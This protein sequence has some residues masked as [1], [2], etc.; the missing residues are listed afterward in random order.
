M[1][2]IRLS[3]RCQQD[4]TVGETTLG[5]GL[6]DPVCHFEGL[7]IVKSQIATCVLRRLKRVIIRSWAVGHVDLEAALPPRVAR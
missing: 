5:E 6:L 2:V 3:H 4:I 7:V 1:G